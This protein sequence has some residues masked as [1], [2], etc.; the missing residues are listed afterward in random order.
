MIFMKEKKIEIE[1]GEQNEDENIQ[2]LF[3]SIKL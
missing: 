2:N 1:K 3:S